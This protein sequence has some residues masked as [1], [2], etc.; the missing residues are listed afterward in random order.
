MPQ[1]S[2]SPRP[3]ISQMETYVAVKPFE[4]MS[5]ELGR[6]PADIIKLDANENPYGPS[7]RVQE[8]LSAY[9]WLHIY[10]DPQQEQLRVALADYVGV[11]MENIFPGHGAD[12]IIDLLCRV[13]LQPGDSII[14]C[15]PTFGMYSF[16]AKLSGARVIEVWRDE[17]FGLD[18]EGIERAVAVAETPPKILF[19]TSPNNPDGG[20]VS[21]AT[22]RRLLQLPLL[23]VV[24]EAYI[25]FAEGEGSVA[26][27]VPETPNLAVLRTFSKWAGLAGLRLGYGIFPLALMAHLWKC[28]QP[29]NVNVAA[30][31]AGLAS[32]DDLPL[33]QARVSTLKVER[34]RMYTALQQIPALHPLPG[35]G[36]FILCRV[37]GRPAAE[38]QRQLAAQGILVRHYDKAGLRNY[39]RISAGRPQDSER[40]LAALSRCTELS[41]SS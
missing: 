32:L 18:V 23:V 10:P 11:S 41:T 29:Y 39:L 35:Q 1:H 34:D 9:P 33:L 27:W 16:D 21:H 31:V 3:D 14:T 24:D 13:F 25:E 6:D 26:G 38:L 4:V 30:A 36:N 19:L 5:E 22:L 7:P 37:E 2:P 28:K 40:L 20:L 17:D 15:P 12:E 8:A